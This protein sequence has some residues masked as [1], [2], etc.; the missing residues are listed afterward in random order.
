[1]RSKTRKITALLISFIVIFSFFSIEFATSVS[2]ATNLSSEIYKLAKNYT[3]EIQV[4]GDGFLST[5]TGFFISADGNIVTNYHVIEG[6]LSIT[7]LDSSKKVYSCKKIVA[8]DAYKDLAIIDID[9]TGHAYAKI[10][11]TYDTGDTIYTLGSSEGLTY[12][13]ADGVVSTKSRKIDGYKEDLR[14][15]QIS[16]P[17]SEGNSGGPLI[18]TK[19]EVIGVNA[20]SYATGQNL[21][22]AV[23]LSYLKTITYYNY[24]VA[25]YLKYS[26]L[27]YDTLKYTVMNQGKYNY[28][29]GWYM[30]SYTYDTGDDSILSVMFTYTVSSDLLSFT[31]YDEEDGTSIMIMLTVL[32]N[33]TDSYITTG[34][35]NGYSQSTGVATINPCGYEKGAYT[36]YAFLY[37]L[38][39]ES[40]LSEI[41]S[42][43]F[44]LALYYFEDCLCDYDLSLGDFGFTKMYSP[45]LDELQKCT[46][47]LDPNGGSVYSKTVYVGLGRTVNLPTPTRSGY[48]C[49]GWATS[50]SATTAKYRCGDAC[51]PSL[52]TKLYAVWQIA[53]PTVSSISGTKD[54]FTLKWKK[55][56]VA[57][58]GYQIQYSTSSKF[59][60]PKTVTVSSYKTVSKTVSKLTNGKV[61]YV[62]LRAYRTVSGKKQYTG[63]SGAK[64][65]VVL[66]KATTVSSLKGNK[67]GFTVKW[68]KQTSNVTG[69]QI[70]YSTSSKFTSPKTVTVSSYKTVS[71]TVSKLSKGKKYY[72]RVRTYKT[73]SGK[74]YYSGWS[75]CKSVKTKK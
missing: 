13:F 1:M 10:S 60:S 68:K 25:E 16:A 75:A 69:Y 70:Q 3:V 59:T 8:Y 49:L 26:N 53:P 28:E 55:H 33:G 65:V 41:Y 51:L 31:Y 64:S 17:I 40:T 32:P 9:V 46:L 44:G 66:P 47:T 48:K 39:I 14:F 2:A 22:F 74:K 38:G 42:E 18:N 29:Y 67:G 6:A 34:V 35:Y 45:T 50:K 27:A 4:E 36:D 72:V 21:N 62:R 5:G 56:P 37:D 61:Y 23:P 57:V 15:I 30:L 24:T 7:V 12:T 63:W 73:V 43:Y 52:N 19:G 20:M 71:K 11:Y 54:G 58:S